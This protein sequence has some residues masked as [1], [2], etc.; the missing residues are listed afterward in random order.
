MKLARI[1]SYEERRTI[2][3]SVLQLAVFLYLFVSMT[4]VSVT[5]L[6][7]ELHFLAAA[8]VEKPEAEWVVMTEPTDPQIN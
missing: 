4:L 2:W 8:S 6:P 1:S 5:L 3:R 7:T